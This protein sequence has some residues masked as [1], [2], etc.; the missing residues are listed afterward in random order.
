[1]TTPTRIAK[2]V[3]EFLS[4]RLHLINEDEIREHKHYF[5][6]ADIQ[7]II[8]VITPPVQ[9]VRCGLSGTQSSSLALTA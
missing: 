2:P 4:Y 7:E 3:L 6:K 8:A 9:N 1:M 5:N